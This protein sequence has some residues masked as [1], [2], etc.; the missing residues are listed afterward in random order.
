MNPVC[1]KKDKLYFGIL[2]IAF[3]YRP[4]KMNKPYKRVPVIE[5]FIKDKLNGNDIGMFMWEYK[6][7]GPKYIRTAYRIPDE[8][9][10]DFGAFASLY[11]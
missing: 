1:M 2:N 9:I 10:E 6:Q 5:K 8:V 11:Y 3:N 4:Y 7:Y